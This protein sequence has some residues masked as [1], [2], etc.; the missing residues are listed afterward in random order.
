M[1]RSRVNE[2]FGHLT[3]ALVADACIRLGLPLRLAPQAIRP[4]TVGSRV[5]GRALPARHYGS[6]DI[7]LEAME[8][9]EPGDILVIDNG[10]RTDEACIGDLVALEAHACRLPGIVVWGCHRDT[11]DL[12]RIGVSVFSAGSCPAGPTRL[13]AREAA[14]LTSARVGT[15]EVDANDHVVADDDGVLFIA[16]ERLEPVLRTANAIWETERRQA[17]AVKAGRTLREQL[18]FTQYLAKRSV[19]P[20]HTFRDHLRALGGAIEE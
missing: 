1:T 3:T 17:E 16:T 4:L 5:L 15:C 2:T 11:G 12:R 14:A 6:V 9:S 20:G 13:A 19:D 10:G 18:R 7:F 8:G